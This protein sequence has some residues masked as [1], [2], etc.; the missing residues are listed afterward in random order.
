MASMILEAATRVLC[1]H[2]HPDDETL[3]TGAL[4]AHLHDVG[5]PADVLTAT[6]GEMGETTEGP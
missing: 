5:I 1:C 4:L 2:A 3:S 6:R